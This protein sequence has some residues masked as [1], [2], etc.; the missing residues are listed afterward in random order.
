[1]RLY[2]LLGSNQGNRK[3][4]LEQATDLIRQR[5]GAVASASPQYETA[6]WG[7][8][9]EGED[10]PFLNQALGVETA[11]EPHEVLAITQ[12][13]ET[14]LGRQRQPHAEASGMRI[15]TSRP[16]DIDII[17]H[18]ATVCDTPDLTLPHPRMHLRRFVLQPLN[19]IAPDV[20]H[21]LLHKTVSQL[22]QACPE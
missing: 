22:L 15:Y 2:L 3:A 12:G 21:P 5:V 20:V 4:L 6:P 18:G 9:A 8:F 7:K 14:E 10:H 13:I 1:M 19:D 16:I 17:F 11:K